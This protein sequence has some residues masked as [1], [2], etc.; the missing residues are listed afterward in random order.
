MHFSV[1][2]CFICNC[3]VLKNPEP[4]CHPC[5][6]VLSVASKHMGQQENSGTPI[7]VQSS[8]VFYIAAQQK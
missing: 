4:S 5:S 8:Q 1:K 3:A 2:T 6:A 7:G